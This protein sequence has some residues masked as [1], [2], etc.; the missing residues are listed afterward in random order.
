MLLDLSSDCGNL[1]Q[2]RVSGWLAAPVWRFLRLV[3]GA[4]TRV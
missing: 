2:V 1:Y 3:H 4:E